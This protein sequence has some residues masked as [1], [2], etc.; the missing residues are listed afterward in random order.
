MKKLILFILLVASVALYV[1][2]GWEHSSGKTYWTDRP[3]AATYWLRDSRNDLIITERVQIFDN[4]LKHI[5][6]GVEDYS[7]GF[8]LI[9][10][11]GDVYPN[12]DVSSAY[13]TTNLRYSG[14]WS[15]VEWDIDG[16][17]D[18]VPK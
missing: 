13:C 6:D 9:D 10:E 7:F 3:T 15:D 16:D 8:W 18:L 14:A 2:A 11:D 12:P 4:T 17:G 1:H 5:K